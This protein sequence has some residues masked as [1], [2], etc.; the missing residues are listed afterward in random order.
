MSLPALVAA[1]GA[2]GDDLALG[3]LL[4]GGVGNDDAAGGL[5]LGIDALDDDTVVKRTKFHGVLLSYWAEG[6]SGKSNAR[7]NLPPMP[8]A[9]LGR[10]KRGHKR[11]TQKN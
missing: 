5:L 11:G 4:L 2:D 10:A 7:I 9:D 1:A 3:G 8:E 6:F